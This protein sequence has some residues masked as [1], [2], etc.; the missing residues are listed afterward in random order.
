MIQKAVVIPT[1]NEIMTGVVL[2]T[3]SPA[4]L[5]II[6]EKYPQALVIRA[7]PAADETEEIIRVLKLY[8]DSDL[9]VLIGGSG[10]GKAYDPS[11]ADDVTHFALEKVLADRQVQEIYG[12]NG[13][14]WS[15]LI[16]GKLGQTIVANV[17][18]P[19]VE[20]VAAAG[21]IVRGLAQGLDLSAISRQTAQAV[22]AQYPLG[23]Q[24]RC[25]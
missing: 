11:L 9:I 12:Y 21:V 10:G 25:L 7:Q 19:F 17:P 23:G 16:I 8:G 5:E 6:L 4:I 22:L 13:H 20:A 2:D 15:R 18:G 3:N 1:G 24:V 14:L